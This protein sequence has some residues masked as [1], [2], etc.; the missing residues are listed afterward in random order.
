MTLTMWTL[1]LI[2]IGFLTA[3]TVSANT[4]YYVNTSGQL[5][6]QVADSAT[7]ALNEASNIQYNS[8]V[9]DAE[10]YAMLSASTESYDSQ[11]AD[12]MTFAYID[13]AGELQYTSA[14]SVEAALNTN[15]IRFNSGV[16]AVTE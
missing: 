6:M 5:E 3:T 16:M 14:M 10:E 11:N 4:Y 1:T 9:I 8:G 15:D 7:E 12:G 13:Q 2:G